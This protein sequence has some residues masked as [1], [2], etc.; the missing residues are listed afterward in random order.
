MQRCRICQ[1]GKTLDEF[2]S[3]RGNTRRH[4]CKQCR[5]E[6]RQ[7]R[8]MMTDRSDTA[9]IVSGGAVHVDVASDGHRDYLEGQVRQLTA[10]I[11]SLKGT[12]KTDAQRLVQLE[13]DIQNLRQCSKSDPLWNIM[14][15]V[16]LSTCM[17]IILQWIERQLTA[18]RPARAEV[19]RTV[20]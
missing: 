15:I 9:S 11:R 4:E 8:A 18:F 19:T 12:T 13:I 16:A 2:E 20:A 5:R 14:L 6:A 7:Q 1:H 17:F 3:V 10:D